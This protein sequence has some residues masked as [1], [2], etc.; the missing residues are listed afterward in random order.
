MQKGLG[1]TAGRKSGEEGFFYGNQDVDEE[2]ENVDDAD[3]ASVF[4][5]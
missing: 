1:F 5:L 3:G 4:P 2:E